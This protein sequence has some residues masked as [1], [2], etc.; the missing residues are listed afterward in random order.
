M[1]KHNFAFDQQD[2][3][4]IFLISRYYQTITRTE[5]ALHFKICFIEDLVLIIQGIGLLLYI[6]ILLYEDHED[7]EYFKR[8]TDEA[9]C[10]FRKDTVLM[11]QQQVNGSALF[12]SMQNSGWKCV[13]K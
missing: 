10:L 3:T 13:I 7:H 11:L 1:P 5:T 6:K 2:Y 12:I 9:A 8:E 4:G